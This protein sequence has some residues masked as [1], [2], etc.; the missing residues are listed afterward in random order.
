ME[1]FDLLQ[2]IIDVHCSSRIVFAQCL[3]GMALTGGGTICEEAY[4]ILGR[5]F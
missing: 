3:E 4:I 1:C 2:Q 5:K